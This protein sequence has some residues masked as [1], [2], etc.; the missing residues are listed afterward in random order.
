MNDTRKHITEQIGF[1]THETNVYRT[2]DSFQ[3]L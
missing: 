2:G 3:V 1:T